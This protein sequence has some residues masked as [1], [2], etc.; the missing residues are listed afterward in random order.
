MKTRVDTEGL[1]R[2]QRSAVTNG[3]RLFVEGDGSSAWS[4]RYKDLIAAHASDLGGADVLSEAQRSLVRRASAIELEL[5]QMEGRLS[6]GEPVD[7]DAFTRAAGHLRRIL[8][9]LG[10][11]RRPRDITPPLR[12]YLED[13]H[14]EAAE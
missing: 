3:R 11:E 12:T 7:L 1:P 8:E 10:L 2:R 14:A 6:Q 5:E 4:R 13:V 9:T